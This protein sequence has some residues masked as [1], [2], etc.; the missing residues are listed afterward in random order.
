MGVVYNEQASDLSTRAI[1]QCG[2]S[3]QPDLRNMALFITTEHLICRRLR[4]LSM[5]G[6]SNLTHALWVCAQRPGIGLV[7]PCDHS[8]GLAIQPDLRNMGVV[9]KDKAFD[10][11]TTAIP[12]YGWFIQPGLRNMGAVYKRVSIQTSRIRYCCLLS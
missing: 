10:L 8:V 11:S 6:P 3:I 9:Y 7:D 2:W 1:P 12:Q 4:L 5:V